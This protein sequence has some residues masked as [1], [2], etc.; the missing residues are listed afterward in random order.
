MRQVTDNPKLFT[1]ENGL[2]GDTRKEGKVDLKMFA[3]LVRSPILQAV[4]FNFLI[5]LF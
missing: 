4:E 3:F 5:N 2:H 1:Q